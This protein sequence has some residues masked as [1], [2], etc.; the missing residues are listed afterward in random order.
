MKNEFEFE[1]VHGIPLR[2]PNPYA[3]NPHIAEG[4]DKGI[5]QLMDFGGFE[6]NGDVL[7]VHKQILDENAAAF[8]RGKLDSGYNDDF[9]LEITLKEG[10][11]PVYQR[12]FRLPPH[13]E[14]EAQ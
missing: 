3:R 12:P 10:A 9:P 6:L 7:T 14:D 2:K 13:L 8:M 1:D 4:Y 5:T 11:T